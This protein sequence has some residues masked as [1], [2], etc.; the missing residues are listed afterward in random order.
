MA[1]VVGF[2]GIEDQGQEGIELAAED[3]LAGVRG[4]RKVIKDRKGRVVE[5][6]ESVRAPRD[7]EEG[8]LAIDQRLQFL[9]HREL[10]N[11]VASTGS[12]AGPVGVL[13]PAAGRD[14]PPL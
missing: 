10:K 2:T 13:R 4:S 5:D 7:G 9:A 1:H 6:V 3:R 14:L 8:V 11:A 12:E